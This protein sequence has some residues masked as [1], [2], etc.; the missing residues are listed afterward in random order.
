MTR[1]GSTSEKPGRGAATMAARQGIWTAQAKQGR[2]G[3]WGAGVM[4]DRDASGWT[5]RNSQPK[6]CAIECG[7]GASK[8][9]HAHKL[10]KPPPRLCHPHRHR[11]RSRPTGRTGTHGNEIGYAP[12]PQMSACPQQAIGPRTSWAARTRSSDGKS[13]TSNCGGG[14]RSNSVLAASGTCTARACIKAP[15]A[16]QA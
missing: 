2:V 9:V 10:L 12:A 11:H 6:L 8:L 14:G 3:S 5:H 13:R 16:G 1:R 7:G 15:T 4:A